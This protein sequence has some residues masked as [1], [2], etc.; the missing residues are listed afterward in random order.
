MP[1][2]S[3]GAKMKGIGSRIRALREVRGIKQEDLAGAVGWNKSI[4]SRLEGGHRNIETDEVSALLAILKVTGDERDEILNEVRAQ[5]EPGWWEKQPGLTRDSRTL[6]DYE[7]DAREIIDWAPL[8]IPGL[9]QTMD[10]A[11]AFMD[12][13]QLPMTD[14]GARLAMRMQRQADLGKNGTYRAYIGQAALSAT[15]GGRRVLAAQ[16][17]AL[18]EI[19][20]RDGIEIRVVPINVDAHLGQL[21]AFMFLELKGGATV[22]HVEMARSAVFMDEQP[23]TDP[24]RT[25]LTQV[26]AVAFGETESVRIITKHVAELES[27]HGDTE[28]LAEE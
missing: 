27:G 8:L 18:L 23:L 22:V 14:I 2:K 10:Y 17:R 7:S 20:E 3:P 4:L 21:G 26:A 28:D 16:L 13:Y 25:A 19:G 5:H 6:V 15:V 11:R 12:I 1:R 9:L 24:Y